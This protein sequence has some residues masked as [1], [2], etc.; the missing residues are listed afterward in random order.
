MNTQVADQCSKESLEAS[1]PFPEVVSRLVDAGVEHYV[2][3]LIQKTKTHYG[4]NGYVH[5]VLM[6]FEGP[7][8]IPD[9]FDA[10]AVRGAIGAS[11]RGEISYPQFLWRIMDAGTWSYHVFLRGRCAVYLGRAGEFHVERFPGS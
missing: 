2:A 11:Q 5:S 10:D 4:V 8:S 3:D 7:Q 6:G 1:L 9:E